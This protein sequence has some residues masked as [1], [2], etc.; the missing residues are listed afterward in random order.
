MGFFS[1]K[2]K[3]KYSIHLGDS[4]YKSVVTLN[5]IKNSNNIDW[6]WS[7]SPDI[8]PS[9]VGLNPALMGI[10][11]TI[12]AIADGSISVDELDKGKIQVGLYGDCRVKKYD[13]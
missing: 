1:K 9:G 7:Y 4:D 13:V 10:D 2:E 12:M 8:E 6:S 3:Y 11:S 5:R